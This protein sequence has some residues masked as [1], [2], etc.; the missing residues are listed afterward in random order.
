[1][2]G[3][4]VG[5]MNFVYKYKNKSAHTVWNKYVAEYKKKKFMYT[6]YVSVMCGGVDQEFGKIKI[7]MKQLKWKW[8]KN[9]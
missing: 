7:K 4:S 9:F 8:K 3:Q 1:M 6:N 5:T 2:S